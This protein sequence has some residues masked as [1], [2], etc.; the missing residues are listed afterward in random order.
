MNDHLKNADVDLLI[1]GMKQLVSREEYYNFFEDILTVAE[2]KSLSVRFKAAKLLY[3]G[4]T[5]LNVAALTGASST[6]ISRISKALSCY[7]ADGYNNV[8]RRMR[9]KN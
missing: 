5:Y 7:G 9:E 6:T 1:E 8:L 4:H 3:E 2:L